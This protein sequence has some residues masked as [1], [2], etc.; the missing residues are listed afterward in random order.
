MRG[1]SRAALLEGSSGKT[2]SE[3]ERNEAR[4]RTVQGDRVQADGMYMQRP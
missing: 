4:K 2:L 3:V 1:R